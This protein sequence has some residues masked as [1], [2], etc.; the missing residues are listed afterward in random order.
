M[1]RARLPSGGPRA[2]PIPALLLPLLVELLLAILSA[3]LP[4]P[5]LS[6]NSD[7]VATGGT[8]LLW[9]LTEPSLSR[10]VMMAAVGTFLLLVVNVWYRY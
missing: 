9:L 10:V 4:T 8:M 3:P 5:P 1:A 7:V 2:A 6:T